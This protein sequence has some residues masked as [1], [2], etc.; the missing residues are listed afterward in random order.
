MQSK[1]GGVF[2][3]LPSLLAVQCQGPV[4]EQWNVVQAGVDWTVLADAHYSTAPLAG[5]G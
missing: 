4:P 5:S 2:P 3:P 1:G